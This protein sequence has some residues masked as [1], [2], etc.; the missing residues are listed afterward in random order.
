MN[1]VDQPPVADDDDAADAADAADRSRHLSSGY[2]SVLVVSE[3]LALFHQ[4]TTRRRLPFLF[5]L[6]FCFFFVLFCFFVVVVV[7]V[8]C[9]LL[10]EISFIDSLINSTRRGLTNA[11]IT[12]N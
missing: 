12:I 5:F 7:A 1:S 10:K 3:S 6:F 8:V 2:P 9:L 4:L 11:L